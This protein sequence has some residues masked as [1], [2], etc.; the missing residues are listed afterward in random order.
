VEL[1]E[2]AV[3][4]FVVGLTHDRAR[5]ERSRSLLSP[6]EIERAGRFRFDQHRERFI[7][8]RAALRT[9]LGGSLGIE[10]GE[11]EFEYNDYG[12]PSLP[13]D[14]RF[15]L[16]DSFDVAVVALT[17]RNDIGVDV[18]RIRARPNGVRFADRFFAPSE[19]ESIRLAPASERDQWFFSCWT[20]KEA[21]VKALGKG[22][23]VPLKSFIVEGDPALDRPR[24]H[25]PEGWTLASFIPVPGFA[26]AVCVRG[27]GLR[28]LRLQRID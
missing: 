20:R 6:D 7:G 9:V 4:L 21:Y 17:V 8:S 15:N 2:N 19:A 24:L 5:L 3:H 27:S 12:K 28:E 10:P 11:I 1:S 18:E 22:L 13:G 26:G 25:G 14:L 16:T 23:A